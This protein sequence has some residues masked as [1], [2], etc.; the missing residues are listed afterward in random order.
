MGLDSTAGMSGGKDMRIW[1]YA[2]GVLVLGG[3]GAVVVL[4]G[5]GIEWDAVG[6]GWG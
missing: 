1:N 2:A 4:R 3:V 5:G 6:K